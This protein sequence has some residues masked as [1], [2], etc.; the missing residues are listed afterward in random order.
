MSRQFRDA[1]A[2]INQYKGIGWL[3]ATIVIHLGTNGHITDTM[4]DGIMQALGPGRQ[5]YFLTARVPRLWETEVNS[6]L[7]AGAQ[8][9]R[10]AHVLEWR[11]FAGCHDDWFVADGFHLQPPG[12]RGY[13]TFVK[14]ALLGHPL[15]TCTK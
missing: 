14:S 8:R 12:Q 7:H 11:D 15:T 6:T 10:N 9:Y 3:P 13:A 4:F 2:V 5:V 1:V